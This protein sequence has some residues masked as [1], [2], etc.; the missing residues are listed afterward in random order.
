MSRVL[1]R[2]TGNDVQFLDADASVPTAYQ[3]QQILRDRV[4]FAPIFE[5]GWPGGIGAQ[6]EE[7]ALMLIN[8][9]PSS[10]PLEQVR[11]KRK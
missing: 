4:R 7:P 5:Y 2:P 3:I 6:V 1:A 9:D 10:T 8:P 11:L